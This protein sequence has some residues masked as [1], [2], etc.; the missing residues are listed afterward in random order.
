M[1]LVKDFKDNRNTEVKRQIIFI[2]QKN[3]K[4][5]RRFVQE[6]KITV[7]SSIIQ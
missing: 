4:K 5:G 1:T 2:K 3:S 7:A 6:T